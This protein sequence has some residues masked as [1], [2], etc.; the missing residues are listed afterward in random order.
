MIIRASSPTRW[1]IC[2]CEIRTRS[3]SRCI[4]AMYRPLEG[5][6]SAD[7][8]LRAEQL[9]ELQRESRERRLVG[10]GVAAS[11][12][13]D[14]SA[15]TMNRDRAIGRIHNPDGLRPGG[16]PLI[17]LR[18]DLAHAIRWRK[19]F[20]G[21]IRGSLEVLR[22]LSAREPAL[23]DKCHV[24]GTDGVGIACKNESRLG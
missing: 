19:N 9:F 3:M 7:Q 12:L 5:W 11:V 6:Q 10:D 24:S 23:L 22:M 14:L 4:D 15:G 13:N 17:Y 16:Q 20:D 21:K 18:V 8:S 2:F 1:A